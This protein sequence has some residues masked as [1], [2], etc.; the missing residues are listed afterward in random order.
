MS[1]ED[2]LNSETRHKC[3]I[4]QQQKEPTKKILCSLDCMELL[5]LDLMKGYLFSNRDVSH[6][7]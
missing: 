6:I 2:V 4:K 5:T 3:V 7:P 1:H